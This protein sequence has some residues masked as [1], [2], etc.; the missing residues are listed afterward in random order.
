MQIK[1]NHINKMEGH[2]GF[3]ASVLSG[4]VKSAKLEIKE[5][6]RLIEGILIGRH[7]KDVPVIVQ[8]ICGICPVVHN[9][10]AI[11]ALEKA[12]G[13]KISSETKDLR[14]LLEWGQIIHSHALHLFFL[15]LADL[16]DI[17]NDLKVVEKYP[18]E[19][20]MAIKIREFGMEIVKVIGGRVIH[21]LTNEVGGFKKVPTNDEIRKLI[22]QGY[23]ALETAEK[24]GAFF[25]Q[26]KFPNFER[27]TEYV[28][29]DSGNDYSIY[30]GDIVSNKGLHIP[31]EK[32]ENNFHELQ[33]PNEV[34][35]KVEV[36]SRNVYMVG[37]I[38]RINNNASWL[39]PKAELYLESLNYKLP[40]YNPFHNVIY[41]MVEVIH[42]IEE[43]LITLKLL[44]NTDLSGAITRNYEVKEGVGVAAVEAPRGTLYYHIDLDHNGYVKNAN[45]IT[46]TAQSLSHLEHDIALYLNDIVDLPEEKRTQKLRGFIRAYDPCI[47]CAVH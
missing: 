2:A 25:A 33:K 24:L 43:S 1:I 23:E 36:K 38:A 37:A 29:L 11:K 8:R 28:C 10:T 13:V 42:A 21:P 12:M 39:T 18:E 34:I 20:K 9:L 27:E 6:I 17:D 16:L 4:D 15:S 45:I 44:E 31:V 41:Q 30:E 22:E 7:Y 40:D 5:G 26:F 14:K 32:F 47:S 35:K 46:P 3:M 19:T